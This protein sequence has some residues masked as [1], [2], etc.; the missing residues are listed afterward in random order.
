[1][2]ENN[3]PNDHVTENTTN[4]AE[5]GA[6]RSGEVR[7][8]LREAGDA[9]LA[10][11][12]ALGAALG[13]FAEGVPERFKSATDSARETLNSANTEGEVRSW[14]ANVT[15]EAEK[16]FNSFRERD[17]KFTEDAKA[18]LRSSVA[19][20][21]ANFNE[22]LDKLDKNSQG[23]GGVIDDLRGRFDSLVNRLQDQF[24]GEDTKGTENAKGSEN[25]KGGEVIDGEIVE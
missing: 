6:Q 16:A 21:R 14:A 11:G 15:N 18:T 3:T 20:V 13:K 7:D 22:R 2:T 25:A 4:T 17:V 1:M 12:S 5:E 9:L 10:A 8:N 24:A 19:D 23:E